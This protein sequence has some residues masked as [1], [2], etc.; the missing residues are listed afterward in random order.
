MQHV[1][2]VRIPATQ[3][4][5]GHVFTSGQLLNI[6]DAYS[7]PLFYKGVDE[8][9]GFKTRHSSIIIFFIFNP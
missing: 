4:I 1:P 3:G 5:A 2:E 8:E 6:K 9:T 7:H